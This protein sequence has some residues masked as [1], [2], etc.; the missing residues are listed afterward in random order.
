[1]ILVLRNLKNRMFL[2]FQLILVIQVLIV[3]TSYYN[4]V[5]KSINPNPFAIKR[6]LRKML[7]LKNVVCFF[8]S[9]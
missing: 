6:M 5:A 2:L 4:P 3:I 7:I 8:Y 9:P 1:M